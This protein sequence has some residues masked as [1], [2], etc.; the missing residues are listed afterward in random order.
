MPELARVATMVSL[1]T[2]P[3]FVTAFQ[4]TSEAPLAAALRKL[5]MCQYLI[6]TAAILYCLSRSTGF[7]SR[8]RWLKFIKSLQCMRLSIH[9][10]SGFKARIVNPGS[11]RT[12]S[13]DKQLI[14][15]RLPPPDFPA[16]K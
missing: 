7:R 15:I 10:Q 11:S 9:R 13:T 4:K 1:L 6:S 5:S 8:R 12:P 2:C 14:F 16:R 3:P